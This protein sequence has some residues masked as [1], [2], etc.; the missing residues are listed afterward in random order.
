[1]DWTVA[2]S[3]FRVPCGDNSSLLPLSHS[4]GP[5]LVFLLSSCVTLGRL[6]SL[7]DLSFHLGMT[8]LFP[9]LPSQGLMK[10]C[11]LVGGSV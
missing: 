9:C 1:M 3:H 11:L 5:V 10:M 7:S 8:G 6:L 4:W 2:L